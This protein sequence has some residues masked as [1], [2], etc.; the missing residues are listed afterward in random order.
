MHA[1]HQAAGRWTKA[2]FTPLLDSTCPPGACAP[3][4]TS[5]H[6]YIHSNTDEQTPPTHAPVNGRAGTVPPAAGTAGPATAGGVGTGDL[7][8]GGPPAAAGCCEL[9]TAPTP[10]AVGIAGTTAST[11]VS[12]KSG[13]TYVVLSSYSVLSANGL[14]CC[15]LLMVV[16]RQQ[17]VGGERETTEDNTF[18]DLGCVA[19]PHKKPME[20][21]L[22]LTRCLYGSA[23]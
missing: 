17:E 23:M 15:C 16:G 11:V 6:A 5:F 14:S 20:L 3:T 19:T 13:G 18:F 1:V 7:Y 10:P 21:Q 8:A 22:S 4:W 2:C 12:L 9:G